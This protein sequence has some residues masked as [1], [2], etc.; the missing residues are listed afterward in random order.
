MAMIVATDSAAIIA[1]ERL[2]KGFEYWRQKAA[3]RLPRRAEIDPVDIPHLLPHV[4]LV[5]VEEAGRFRYRLVG[6]EARLHHA[7]NPTGRYVDEA[8][9]P[10]AG[11]RIVALY[12]ECVRE[13]RPLYV[14]QEYVLPNGSGVR[15]LSK[16]L[17]T[18]IA[19]DGKNVSQVLVFH[20]VSA[21][22]STALDG[23]IWRHP[24]R[25]LVHVLL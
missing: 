6:S 4:R 2:R 21:P 13:R 15:R 10:P 17:F 18:P 19:E 16:V 22:S 7:T 14:E 23:E 11:P 24:Y 8:L 3:G 9:S 5:D 12:E 1:D 25:E 20:V